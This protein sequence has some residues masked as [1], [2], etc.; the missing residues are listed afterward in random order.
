MAKKKRVKGATVPST[1]AGKRYGCGG[2]IKTKN[3]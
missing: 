3:K 2:K 1:A